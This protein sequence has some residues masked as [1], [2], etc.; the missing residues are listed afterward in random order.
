[1]TPTEAKKQL[2][3]ACLEKRLALDKNTKKAAD[4]AFC[5]AIAAL[6]DFCEADLLL[7]FSPMRG[8]PDMTPLASIAAA[9]GIKIAFPRCE[10]GVMTFH[11]VTGKDDFA[12]DMF[13]IPSPRATLPVAKPT[14]RTLCILPGLAAGRDGSRLGYG[15]GFYDRFLA[16]FEGITVFPIYDCLLFDSL[17]TEATDRP[18]DIL[19]TEKG[20]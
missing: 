18:V 14:A 13:G 5:R 7:L 16:T 6:D 19:I 2:R 3:R 1:M 8:E 11:T 20:E 15:G 9:R 4:E 17:P 12:P 10:D